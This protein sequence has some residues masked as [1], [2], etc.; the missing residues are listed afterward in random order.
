MSALLRDDVEIDFDADIVVSDSDHELALTLFHQMLRIREF[1]LRVNKSFL[2]GHIPGTIHLS[3]GQEACA[4]GACHPLN[5]EDWITITH[6]GHGQALAKGVTAASMM[7]ELFARDGGCCRGYGG[8]LHVGDMSVGAVP[9][10]AIVAD[11]IPITAG[12]AYAFR[13]RNERRVALCFTGDG[14][15]GEGDWHEGLNLAAAWNLP[16]V[17]L[18][19][20]NLYSISTRIDRQF[21][22]T[23]LAARAATYGMRSL[24]VDGN[25]VLAVQR[26]VAAEVERIRNEGGGPVFI[27]CLTYRQGGHKRDD[28]GSYR[29]QEEVD[30]WMGRDP[31]A[32]LERTLVAQ[33]AGGDVEELRAKVSEE[34]DEAVAWAFASP[35]AEWKVDS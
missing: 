8:S 9:A 13:A 3:L 22:N 29:P 11:S 34:L 16:V 30:L 33:G 27:E 31:L 19:E 28:P 14:A 6:R 20:N 12:I 26:A 21:K 7:A 2:E 5:V 18:C 15:A 32:R 25:D 4:A 10:I 23:S 35:L 17:Y 24:V 1:E